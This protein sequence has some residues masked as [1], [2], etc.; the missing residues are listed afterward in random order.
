[1]GK[2]QVREVFIVNVHAPCDMRRKKELWN[3]LVNQMNV[4][5][6]GKWFKT[7]DFNSIKLNIERKGVQNN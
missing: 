5:A 7:G 6:K 2:G 1:M 3:V 4:R